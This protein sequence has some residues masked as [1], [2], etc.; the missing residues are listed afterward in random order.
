MDLKGVPL[1]E[2]N[3]LAAECGFR[4]NARVNRRGHILFRLLPTSDEY[5]K[6]STG[7]GSRGRRVHAVCWHGHRYFMS[8]LFDK[9]PNAVLKTCLAT[10]R[11]LN[12]F[13]EKYPDT[14]WD[15]VGSMIA[16]VFRREACKCW[17][18]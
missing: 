13:E 15:N 11:G 8:H 5:R 3:K 7:W 12:D 18:D 4:T 2:V 1:D 10:Y 14:G 16:P 6:I 17:E 9:F